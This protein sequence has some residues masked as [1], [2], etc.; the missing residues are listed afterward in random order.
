ML[1]ISFCHDYL[2]AK[3]DNIRS[4]SH[5]NIPSIILFD[6]KKWEIKDIL[7]FTFP[8]IEEDFLSFEFKNKILGQ[9]PKGSVFKSI[10]RKPRYGMMGLTVDNHSNQLYAATWNGIYNINIFN[11]NVDQFLSHQLINDPHGIDVFDN[12]IYSIVTPLDL[13]VETCLKSGKITDFFS[14][15]R[16]LSILKDKS[17]L[18]YDW[19]FISKQSRG[20]WGNWHFNFIRVTKD[21]IYLTSRLTSSM[22]AINR[23]KKS[24]ELRTVCWDTPVMIHDGILD[25][26]GNIVF[27]SVDGKI[28]ICN[29]PE[30]I[31]Y[32]IAHDFDNSSFHKY[33]NRDLVNKSIRLENILKRPINWCRGLA[34]NDDYY[35]TTI[36]GRY[37]QNKPYFTLAQISKIDSQ[38]KEFRFSYEILKF[39]TEI[40][41]MTGF[42]VIYLND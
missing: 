20:A 24:A 14:V 18:E 21:T 22:V 5:K 32:T 1:I 25:N 13:I 2:N 42:S 19:R 15:S 33:M 27:T 40:R 23:K 10:G 36:D 29:T 7:N 17:I 39:P 16:N 41:Y 38:V 34:D 4:L 30:K 35:F 28:L 8:R 11:K 3:K 12:K 9:L 6:E 37:D 31:N 26:D